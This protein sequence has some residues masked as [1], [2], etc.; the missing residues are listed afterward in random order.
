MY[1]RIRCRKIFRG[2][3]ITLKL[4]KLYTIHLHQLSFFSFHG[5]HEEEKILG[6]YF[7]VSLDITMLNDILVQSIDDTVNY[8]EVYEIVKYK[9]NKPTLLLEVL[10]ADMATAIYAFNNRINKI[11]ITIKKVTPPLKNFSGQVGV[12]F[13]KIFD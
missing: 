10:A 8:A 1:G 6:N 11:S 9:M 12:T 5:L 4:I 13:E 7:E 3:G 2:K